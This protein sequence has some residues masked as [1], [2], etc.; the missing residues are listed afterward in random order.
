MPAYLTPHADLPDPARR[1]WKLGALSYED[2][3]FPSYF[4][5]AALCLKDGEYKALGILTPH[6]NTRTWSPRWRNLLMSIDDLET[7]VG[8]DFFCNLPDSIEDAIEATFEPE[9][10]G[11]PLAE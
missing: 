9:A 3:F 7:A 5:C 4:Y 2:L 8:Q 10:W 1:P 11:L 6:E